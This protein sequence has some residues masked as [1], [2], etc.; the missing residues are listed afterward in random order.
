M[1]V[2]NV[3]FTNNLDFH[4]F[5]VEDFHIGYHLNVFQLSKFIWKTI[6]YYLN[7]YSSFQSLLYEIILLY[8]VYY[9]LVWSESFCWINSS[10]F[11]DGHLPSFPPSKV[12]SPKKKFE[13]V[14]IKR[15]DDGEEVCKAGWWRFA[16]FSFPQN[17]KQQKRKFLSRMQFWNV[18]LKMHFLL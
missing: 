10:Y 9:F 3:S 5:N 11:P 1:P 7:N 13:K 2:Y 18:M 4:K 14:F 8:W 6:C 17:V 12:C 15:W 16:K